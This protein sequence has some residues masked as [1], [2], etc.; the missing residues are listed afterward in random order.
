MGQEI[1][2][3]HF[4]DAEFGVFRHKLEDETRLFTRWIRD[5]RFSSRGPV[6]GFELEAW[7]VD[8]AMEP[9]PLNR[10]FLAALNNPLASPE[11]ALFNVE[12]NTQ[13]QSLTGPALSLLY[14][15]LAGLWAEATAAADRLGVQ[16]AA[17]G[18]LPTVREAVLN[19]SHIS[20][21][22]RYH[23]LNEQILAA[24][25]YQPLHLKISGHEHLESRHQDVMLEAATTSFQIHLQVPWEKA[26]DYFN[27]ALLA[28]APLVG[29]AANSPFLF[30]RDLWAET[31]IPLFEQ[32]AEAG[33][34]Q[35]AAHG[36]LRRVSFGSDYAKSGLAELFEENLQHF[37]ILLP[38][39]ADTAPERFAHLRLHNG[40]I[41]RWNRP[42]IG[43]DPDRTPHLRIEHRVIPAGPS[44]VDMIAN[45]ALF[46]GLTETFA[47]E[48]WAWW[49][50]FPTARDNFYQAARHGLH[51]PVIDP[52]GEKQRLGVW[53]LNRL[54]PA[55]EAGLRRLALAEADI[56]RY[57]GVIEGRAASG[58]I[59]SE[60]QRR[61]IARHPGDF[62]ALL[63][64]YLSHQRTGEPVHRW[65][66]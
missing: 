51:A 21:M 56:V 16:L 7:L 62:S 42:L 14:G 45:A 18:I 30:G 54:L 15:E 12:F 29:V 28:S 22:N 59:G 39:V 53:L 6:T 52:E 2:K 32:A 40:T 46:F 47:Q 38:L 23:A 58:L 10:E 3:T 63:G 41:W 60:W 27:A 5:G 1:G 43:F 37:P 34:Y 33:G 26:R 11:L 35:E 66:L 19:L 44:L 49:L 57:L 31:R 17:I 61:F 20:P 36:P 64:E 48:P 50:P 4:S 65:P 13:P 9:A 55:A 8:S 25:G 24:R